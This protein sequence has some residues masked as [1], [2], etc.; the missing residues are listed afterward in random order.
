MCRPNLRGICVV[1]RNPAL[2][3]IPTLAED[4]VLVE[5]AVQNPVLGHQQCISLQDS[6]SQDEQHYPG[7]G[8]QSYIDSTQFTW[9]SPKWNLAGFSGFN[10]ESSS[11]N[12]SLS[13]GVHSESNSQAENQH[14]WGSDLELASPRMFETCVLGSSWSTSTSSMPLTGWMDSCTVLMLH[15]L[16]YFHVSELEY[17]GYICV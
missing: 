2:Y 15:Y 12:D 8:G 13:E 5:R 14:D 7:Y 3:Y 16:V 17:L 9:S 10:V 1:C 4:L 11:M 6:E